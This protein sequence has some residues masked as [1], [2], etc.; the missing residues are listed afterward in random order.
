VTV[1]DY[2][3]ERADLAMSLDVIF[4]LVEDA[5]YDQ[6]LERL[7]AAGERYVVV[8]STSADMPGTGVAHVRHRDVEAD[9]PPV[10]EFADAGGGGAVAAARALR[11]R[12]AGSVLLYARG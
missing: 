7:F 2:R 10:P 4:H 6:Y 5:V 3:G 11:P 9:W 8:Y 1:A 12:P